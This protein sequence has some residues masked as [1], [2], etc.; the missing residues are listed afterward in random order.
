VTATVRSDNSVAMD[1]LAGEAGWYLYG[2]TWPHTPAP[3]GLE[4]LACG[5]VAA[6]VRRVPLADFTEDALQARLRDLSALEALAREHHAAIEDVHRTHAILPVKFGSVYP[7]TEVLGAALVVRQAALVEQLR[8]VDGCDEWA[9]HVRIDQA[10]VER[11]T[12]ERDPEVAQLE[13]RLAAATPGHAWF[14]QRK[15][16]AARERAVETL[17]R[18]RA[19]VVWAALAEHVE[20]GRAGTPVTLEDGT[21]PVLRV[22][23]LVRR[24]ALEALHA[25]VAGLMD[26]FPDL[27]WESSGPWPPYSFVTSPDTE[28]GKP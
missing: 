22:A 25:C 5:E 7:G 21:L 27:R 9:L 15:L 12:A 19:E 3:P 24:D 11:L 26:A 16:A 28:K 13:S 10:L 17:V 14:L 20:E 2:V 8:L 4:M 6:L 1:A 18:A 23:V